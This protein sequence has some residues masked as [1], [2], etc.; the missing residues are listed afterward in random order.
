MDGIKRGVEMGKL[1]E[2]VGGKR[3]DGMLELMED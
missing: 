1:M 2:G 3:W